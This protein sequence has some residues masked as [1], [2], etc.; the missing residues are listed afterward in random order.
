MSG[1]V[2]FPRRQSGYFVKTYPI[3]NICRPFLKARIE[4]NLVFS[5]KKAYN[6]VV[7]VLGSEGVGMGSPS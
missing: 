5:I 6:L 4:S 1:M 2:D 7:C 3:V